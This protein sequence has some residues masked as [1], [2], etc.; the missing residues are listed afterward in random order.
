MK[1]VAVVRTLVS[2]SSFSPARKIL[3]KVVLID[4]ISQPVDERARA[5][6]CMRGE[7]FVGVM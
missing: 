4:V 7:I 5:R 1:R 2:N 6:V 3:T